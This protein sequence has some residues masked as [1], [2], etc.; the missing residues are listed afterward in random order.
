M[1]DPQDEEQHPSDAAQHEPGAAEALPTETPRPEAPASASPDDGEPAA[2]GAEAGDTGLET[3]APAP[4]PDFW[5]SLDAG[6]SIAGQA[7]GRTMVSLKETVAQ[8]YSAIDPDLRRHLAQ[9][10]LM[11]LTYLTPGRIKLEALPDDGQRVVIFVHGL[12]GHRGN[13]LAMQTYF[14]WMG[15]KRVLSVGFQDYDSIAG[16]AAQLSTLIREVIRI[17]QLEPTQSIELVTHSMGGII[18]RLALEDPEMASA[19][20]TLITLGTPHSGTQLARLLQTSKVRDLRPG[21]E[22]L[23]RLQQQLPWPGHPHLPP[24][25]A[26]WSPADLVL[27]P[28]ESAAVAGA[29]NIR[30]EDFSHFSYLI[31]PQSW[32][33]VFDLLEPRALKAELA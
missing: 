22:L 8:A 10:P 17:N 20:A 19:V 28:A 27:M 16:M 3:E 18:A 14:R 12:G 25:V 29:Q 5:A 13:F 31:H 24:L 7:I 23:E 11:G 9:L 6:L 33:R 30:V 15:R 2:G 1:S 21:S 26:I 32:K 4:G